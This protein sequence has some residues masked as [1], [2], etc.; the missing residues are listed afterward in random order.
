VRN[1]GAILSPQAILAGFGEAAI[2]LRSKLVLVNLRGDLAAAVM[3]TNNLFH[4]MNTELVSSHFNEMIFITGTRRKT[5]GQRSS[6]PWTYPQVDSVG[7]I[8]QGVSP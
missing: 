4:T 3:V 8:E 5:L 2:L 1:G 6:A 7:S